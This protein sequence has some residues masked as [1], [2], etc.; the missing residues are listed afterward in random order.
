MRNIYRMNI[1][2]IQRIIRIFIMKTNT[3]TSKSNAYC[4]VN[5]HNEW[6]LLEEVIVGVVD[7]A[8]FP[9]YH[10]TLEATM[11]HDQLGVFRE[12]AGKPFPP[13]QIAMAKKELDEFVHILEGEGIKVRRPLPTD[14]LQQYGAP[15]WT[16]TGLYNAMPRDVLL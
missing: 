15:G 7:G 4:P 9:P 16:S 13:E 6:D 10:I 8:T 12:N 3:E 5:S 1:Q 14:Q 2:I 11:P